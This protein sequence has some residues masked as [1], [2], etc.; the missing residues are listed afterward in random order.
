MVELSG[1]VPVV[2][3]G[4]SFY[5]LSVTIFTIYYSLQYTV[6]PVLSRPHIKWT[7]DRELKSQ[8]FLP[9]FTAK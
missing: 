5:Q 8:N 7:P 2:S 9:T 4:V 1:T 6:K 3:G